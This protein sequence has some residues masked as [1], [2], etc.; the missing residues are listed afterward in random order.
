MN[1]IEDPN[2]PNEDDPEVS[3]NED[4]LIDSDYYND[5]ECM[6]TFLWGKVVPQTPLGGNVVPPA[7]GF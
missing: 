7:K 2:E 5:P 3:C 6:G 1:D 4:E